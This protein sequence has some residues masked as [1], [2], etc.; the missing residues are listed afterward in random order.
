M[1]SQFAD[2]VRNKEP[3]ASTEALFSHSEDQTLTRGYD[4]QVPRGIVFQIEIAP[5][6]QT[7]DSEAVRLIGTDNAN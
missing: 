3:V 2:L 1:V 7:I 5:E 6:S 4:T